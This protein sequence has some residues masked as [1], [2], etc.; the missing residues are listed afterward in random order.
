MSPVSLGIDTSCYTTSVALVGSDGE[1]LGDFRTPLAVK[2]GQ[3]GLRQSEAF[4]QHVLN[5]P[6]LLEAARPLL[7][8]VERLCVSTRPR[9]HPDSYMPV[10]N[11]GDAFAKALG[12]ALNKDVLE[13]SHQEGHLMAVLPETGLGGADCFSAVHLSGGT[14]EILK[15]QASGN[16]FETILAGGSLDITAGQLIDR[17]GVRLGHGFPAG[18]ILDGMISNQTEKDAYKPSVKGGFFNLSGIENQ[19]EKDLASGV[20]PVLVVLKTFNCI[21]E[22]LEKALEALGLSKGPILMMG[23]VSASAFLHRRLTSRFPTVRFGPAGHA[24]DNAIGVARMGV[25]MALGKGDG[26][27]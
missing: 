3:R 27:A 23:G 22:S 4:Y 11:A 21:A 26:E 8:S 14:A 17:L 5:L 20:D 7:P 6:V 12:T 16:R 24:T 9:N 18:K 13:C 1:V 15:V 2:K 25:R 10:F 19:F